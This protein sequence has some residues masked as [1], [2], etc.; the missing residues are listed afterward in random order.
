MEE[1]IS[2]R[3]RAELIGALAN[4]YRLLMVEMLSEG[5]ICVCEFDRIL[6]LD[7]S[8]ISRHLAVLRKSGIA[9][10]RKSGKQV[11]YSLRVPCVLGFLSCFDEILKKNIERDK[12]CLSRVEVAN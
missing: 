5:E 9:G 12:Q 8:T 7:Y 6:D 2:Y 11:F 4:P 1:M 10:Y 3:K